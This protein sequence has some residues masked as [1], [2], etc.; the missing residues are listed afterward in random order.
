M[1]ASVDGKGELRE[2]VVS[3]AVADPGNAQGLADLIVS[4]VRD[5]QHALVARN[6][7]AAAPV[8]RAQDGTAG[9][10]RLTGLGPRG[11]PGPRYGFHRTAAPALSR[12]RTALTRRVQ[13][14]P[15][16]EFA[17]AGRVTAGV[18]PTA[19]AH[20]SAGRAGRGRWT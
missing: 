14:R 11:T 3:P 20:G 8:E 17:E 9:L 19:A 12:G 2:L 4:A 7:E 1:K 10:L 18:E 5:A 15:Q 6:E 16:G 13:V